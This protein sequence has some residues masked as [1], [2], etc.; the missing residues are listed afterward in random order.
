MENN[1]HS[2]P[3][4]SLNQLQ[5][6]RNLVNVTCESKKVKVSVVIPI[7]RESFILRKNI[8]VLL[9][10]DLD[11]EIIVV[12]DEPTEKT[13]EEIEKVDGIKVVIHKERV[14]KVNAINEALSFCNG[15]VILFLDGDVELPDSNEFLRK[16]FEEIKGYD[17]LD[18]RKIIVRDSFLAKLIY[19]DYASLNIFS[20][21]S[22]KSTKKLITL[23]GAAFAIKKEVLLKL[24]GFN[25]MITEDIDLA[26]RLFMNGYKLKY[27]KNI[28]VY[29]YTHSSLRKWFKQR[30]RWAK[31]GA[32]IVAVYNKKLMLEIVKN[33]EVFFPFLVFL[34]P[35]F[36]SLIFYPLVPN[37]MI[38]GISTTI[39]LSAGYIQQSFI[40]AIALSWLKPT[41]T[42]SFIKGIM[43]MIV[44]TLV[45]FVIF[46]ISS[47]KLGYN[48]SILEFLL[49]YFFYSFLS[50]TVALIGFVEVL[51]MKKRNCENWKV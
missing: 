30:L 25:K 51:I 12:I 16:V 37:S 20:W 6:E 18:I 2:C 11:K 41:V 26:I 14:G 1:Q 13:K 47:K 44:S 31:G 24:D 42:I 36:F 8:Q 39:I 40:S 34:F 38:Y 29:C 5:T 9:K 4:S 28:F 49:F 15:E 3:S 33:F 7:Y 19:Y 22:F 43:T 21:L 17:A 10:Q 48:F 27:S 35:S 50:F 45:F 23:N 46:Y 32:E